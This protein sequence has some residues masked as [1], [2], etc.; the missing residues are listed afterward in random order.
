M[1]DQRPRRFFVLNN[2]KNS[3]IKITIYKIGKETKKKYRGNIFIF[4]KKFDFLT[5]KDGQPTKRER[6]NICL[7]AI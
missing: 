1:S 3:T 4:V 7:N 6:V 2:N 5:S